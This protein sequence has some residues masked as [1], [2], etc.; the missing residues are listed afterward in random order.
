MTTKEAERY[1]GKYRQLQKKIDILENRLNSLGE[2]AMMGGG[3]LG[4]ERVMGGQPTTLEDIVCQKIDVENRYHETIKVAF[5]TLREIENYLNIILDDKPIYYNILTLYYIDDVS[6]LKIA[7]TLNYSID[8]TYVNRR[9]AL[10][11]F[12]N[13]MTIRNLSYSLN[14]FKQ[15]VVASHGT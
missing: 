9:R 15:K 12:A 14:L 5:E 11:Y 1:L 8:Y 6:M 3:G 4:G 13:E 10:K 2:R 7:E